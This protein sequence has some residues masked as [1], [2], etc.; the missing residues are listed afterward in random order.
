MDTICQEVTMQTCGLYSCDMGQSL[1]KH[2]IDYYVA[3]LCDHLFS[4]MNTMFPHVTNIL[5]E[6]VKGKIFYWQNK[7]RI[8]SAKHIGKKNNQMELTEQLRN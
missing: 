8:E 5:K 7:K 6:S 4:F 1:P 2:I 3:L